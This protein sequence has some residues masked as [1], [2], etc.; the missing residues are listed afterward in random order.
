MASPARNAHNETDLISLRSR[1][2]EKRSRQTSPEDVASAEASSSA[3]VPV[4]TEKGVDDDIEDPSVMRPRIDIHTRGLEEKEVNN[5]D[6]GEQEDNEE[7]DCAEHNH[8]SCCNPKGIGEIMA[9]GFCEAF[10]NVIS[11][12]RRNI[13]KKQMFMLLGAIVAAICKTKNVAV[14]TAVNEAAGDAAASEAASTVS[15]V[16]DVAADATDVVIKT[17]V[18]VVIDSC[19][20]SDSD[21]VAPLEGS[22]AGGVTERSSPTCHVDGHI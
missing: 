13:T 10:N 22:A 11:C 20:G 6:E 19:T 21:S 17:L 3:W 4:D 8:T 18:D 5:D 16:N 15:D 2:V 7:C 9:R 12:I 1:D 14:S